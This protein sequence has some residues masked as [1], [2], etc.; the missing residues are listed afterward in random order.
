MRSSRGVETSARTPG[1]AAPEALN[2]DPAGMDSDQ[3]FFERRLGPTEEMKGCALSG[4]A[5]SQASPARP[6]LRVSR[7]PHFALPAETG[8]DS[9]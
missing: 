6:Q 2:Y 4:A 5:L 8:L 7:E 3:R 9:S 1:F